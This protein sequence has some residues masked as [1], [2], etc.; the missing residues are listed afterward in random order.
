MI[1]QKR[2]IRLS[3][4]SIVG[5]I[6]MAEELDVNVGDSEAEAGGIG[7]R[8]SIFTVF[9]GTTREF[10]EIGS[11][12]EPLRSVKSS[13]SRLTAGFAMDAELLADGRGSDSTGLSATSLGSFFGMR[14]RF[15]TDDGLDDKVAG[16]CE[17]DA[18]LGGLASLSSGG[19]NGCSFSAGR[20]REPSSD[21]RILSPLS[22]GVGPRSLASSDL[23][24]FSTRLS[25][26]CFD[27][28]GI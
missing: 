13:S 24:V 21:L 18:A 14:G 16:G 10:E 4:I 20:L 6:D 27:W 17:D 26:G 11:S 2:E 25:P 8:R 1:V 9:D 3:H 23:A 7:E 19:D 28:L 5:E 12:F 15:I 22:V